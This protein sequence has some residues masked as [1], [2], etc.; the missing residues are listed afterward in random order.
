MPHP[1][2]ATDNERDVVLPNVWPGFQ[3]VQRTAH[4]K[5]AVLG[6]TLNVVGT[7][8]LAAI[9]NA[10][11]VIEPAAPG[12]RMFAALRPDRPRAGVAA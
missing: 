4:P 1:A 7:R 10:G 11:V 8:W 2:A 6:T 9:M 12:Q 3:F 5:A